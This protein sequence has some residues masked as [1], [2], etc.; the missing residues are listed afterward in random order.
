M[1]AVSATVLTSLSPFGVH[2]VFTSIQFVLFLPLVVFLY[3]MTPPA[4]RW[5]VLLGASYLFYMAWKPAYLVLIGVSTLVDYVAG[6]RMEASK[7]PAARRFWLSASLVANL[8]L[9]FSFK[10]LDFALQSLQAALQTVGLAVTAPH[11]DLLL[12]VGISFY[13][14][15]TLSY[16]IDVYRG[17]RPAERHLG[18][19]ALFVSFFPQLVAGPIERSSRLLPQ[20]RSAYAL[21]ADNITAGLRLIAWGFFKKLAIADRLALLVDPIYSS[22]GSHGGL[23]LT[24]A[25]VAFAFQIFCDFSAY[26]DIAVGSARMLGI[27]LMKNFDQPYLAT[28]FSD[29][30]KRWHISLSQWFRDYVYIPLGG[31][32]GNHTSRNLM[33]V[34]MVSGLWHGAN[35]TFVI[36]GALHGLYLIAERKLSPL[37]ARAPSLGFVGQVAKVGLVFALVCFAWIFFRA[38]SVTQAWTIIAG[39]TSGWG[40]ETS[41]LT[42]GSL[43][44]FGLRPYDL[45]VLAAGVVVAEVVHWLSRQHP[46]W[47]RSRSEMTHWIAYQGLGL[48]TL[49]LGV[50]GDRSFIYFQ[51]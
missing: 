18:Y 37:F 12:P 36:W 21:R 38:S 9:L 11:F 2:V 51:F 50:T 10:Y 39:L 26:S 22:P 28:S 27:R 15:Q 1:D 45:F 32:R 49:L 35:W 34:F 47:W 48:A 5:I 14:F 16:T 20:L 19:F 23:A 42:D 41:T 44:Y 43:A 3:Y 30:W 7:A 4:R 8:G 33:I 40:L 29:F 17:H 24:L 6:R 46:D 25:T 31:S 13:T